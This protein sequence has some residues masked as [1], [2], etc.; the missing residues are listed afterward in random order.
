MCVFCVQIAW[1]DIHSH[2]NLTLDFFFGRWLFM[3]S[4]EFDVINNKH[5]THACVRI[6]AGWD[7]TYDKFPYLVRKE[8]SKSG[9]ER[10]KR[11]YTQNMTT[12][13][14]LCGGTIDY[15]PSLK[16]YTIYIHKRSRTLA[17]KTEKQLIENN[18]FKSMTLTLHCKQLCAQI[19]C[20]KWFSICCL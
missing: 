13:I 19:C 8:S 6:C 4:L 17:Y 11:A 2:K 14:P 15:S 1:F 5:N 3:F 10:K 16:L 9:Y 20:E 12:D 7:H 18:K